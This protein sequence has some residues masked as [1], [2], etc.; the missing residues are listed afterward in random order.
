[1]QEKR[2]R[3]VVTFRGLVVSL[4]Y[5]KA[6]RYP[7]VVDDLPAVTL[8]SADVDQM[9]NA[10]LYASEVWAII[11]EIGVGIGLLWRQMGPVALA[12]VFLTPITAGINTVLARLQ[13][14]RRG[15]WLEALQRRVG[16]TSMV[17]GS[18]KSVKLGNMSGTYA[19]RLQEQRVLE[20]DKANRFRW[21]TVWQNTVGKM[22]WKL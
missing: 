2:N 4:I 9:S 12:P 6:L 19:T 13:G 10:V 3:M 18:M 22:H 16:L 7:S 14:K 1:M 20:V 11:V 8:T 17:L 5:D 15:V 21:L